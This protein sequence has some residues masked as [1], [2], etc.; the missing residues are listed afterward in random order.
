MVFNA[1]FNNISVISWWS[2]LLVEEIRVP[3]K[4]HRPAASQC[5][6]S[7]LIIEDPDVTLKCR[8][9]INALFLYFNLYQSVNL[10]SLSCSFTS[11]GPSWSYAHGSWI[12]NYLCN[13]CLSPLMLWVRISLRRGVLDTTVSDKVC[14]GWMETDHVDDLCCSIYYTYISMKQLKWPFE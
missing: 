13:Q 4:K 7:M 9:V 10:D 11:K 5:I 6:M 12:Y 2:V 8:T 3:G 14:L 1:T